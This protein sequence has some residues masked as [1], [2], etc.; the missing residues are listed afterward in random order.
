MNQDLQNKI[1]ETKELL[2]QLKL[3]Q[4]EQKNKNK[5]VKKIRNKN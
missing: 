3:K 5:I 4:K 1:K 2:E